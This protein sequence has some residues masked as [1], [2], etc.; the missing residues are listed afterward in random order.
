LAWPY[1]YLCL[2]MVSWISTF[3]KIIFRWSFPACIL[4]LRVL[5]THPVGSKNFG[6]YTYILK[7]N[8]QQLTTYRIGFKSNTHI[9]RKYF[10]SKN[11]I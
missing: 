5:A 7:N 11:K 2:N 3:F 9:I 4:W 8:A 10:L 1:A 6:Q